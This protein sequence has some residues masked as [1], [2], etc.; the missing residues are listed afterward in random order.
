MKFSI[1]DFF[2]AF[3]Q[4][5][6]K[7]WKMVKIYIRK[8][9]DN[10]YLRFTGSLLDV[11]LLVHTVILSEAH[12]IQR[13]ESKVQEKLSQKH[14]KLMT[15]LFGSPTRSCV[16]FVTIFVDYLPFSWETNSLNGL[17]TH[18][19]FPTQKNLK[20]LKAMSWWGN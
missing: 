5:R 18:M 9:Y 20:V 19:F 2:S 6:R 17:L 15:S 16:Y 12:E 3:Y 13:S 8:K 10:I 7:L 4:I 14:F 11:F 1:K